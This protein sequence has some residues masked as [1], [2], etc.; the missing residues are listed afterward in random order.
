M[1]RLLWLAVL[2]A[3]TVC[4]RAAELEIAAKPE[5]P[6]AYKIVSDDNA[7]GLRRVTVR[8]DR[9]LSES[10]LRAVS[11]TVRKT[12]KA[13]AA[14]D[15]VTFYLPAMK[16][17]QGPW[18]QQQL[19]TSGKITILGLRLDEENAYR[20]EALSELRPV[21]GMWLTSPPAMPGRL[22]I[23]RDRNG[24]TFAEWRLRNGQKTVDELNEQHSSRGRRFDIAGASGAYYLAT[25]GGELELGDTSSVIAVAERLVI[26]KSTASVA[27]KRSLD[28]KASAAP[29]SNARAVSPPSNS[30]QHGDATAAAQ[31]AAHPTSP[32]TGNARAASEKFDAGKTA[33]TH[34]AAARQPSKGMP[35]ESS[36][37]DDSALSS[38]MTR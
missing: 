36:A 2:A 37:S 27:P 13:G 9:R 7:M 32:V 35:A 4:A 16:L 31:A 26:E 18:A 38:A 24:K 5:I 25:W 11:E 6:P 34:K 19:G 29:A 17:A 28:L 20:A 22:T 1:T 23:W 30:A 10:D 21:I 8:I 33:K 3:T 12:Q 14:V 15:T